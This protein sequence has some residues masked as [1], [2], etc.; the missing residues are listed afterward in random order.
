MSVHRKGVNRAAIAS[1]VFGR[2]VYAVN[3]YSLAAVFFLIKSELNQNVSGLGLVIS[4]F[5]VG[6]G[7]SQVPGGILAAK[8]GPRLTA[9]FGTAIASLAVLLTGLAGN[10]VE[11]AILRFFVG[12]GMAF[13]FAPGVTLM[14]RLLR[15]GSEGLGVGIYN[16]A[17]S[18][19]GV[20][21]LSGWS[22]LATVVGWRISLI[23]GGLLGLFTSVLLWVLV[24]EDSRR[25]Q[26]KVELGHLWAVLSDKWLIVVSIAMLGLEVGST[27]YSNFMPY[28][29]ETVAN[30]G[31]GEGGTIVSLAL[32][33]SLASAPF[34]GRLFDRFGNARRLLL[35]SGVLMA[36]G[37]AVAFFGTVYSAV[38]SGILV[39]LA[40]GSG[41]T[42]GFSA[43]RE[44]NKL[45]KEYE[46][47]AISWVN[48]I[49]L[50]GD[51]VPPLLYSYLVLQ[52]G[53]S[54]AWLY[55]AVLA[56]VLVVPVLFTKVSSQKQAQ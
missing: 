55:M 19:G 34:S 6:I 1:L 56:L 54:P 44:A 42:F 52:Y 18:L 39:G 36:L 28:Y 31:L 46:T 45:D 26:F 5:F 24:P 48:S 10:L 30:I 51:F 49:S 15:E 2:V 27:I 21:G 20:I 47:L 29:L 25:S 11:I 37:V 12:F 17:F 41:F 7:L 8:I 50:F 33:F 43:A 40:S 14:T 16:S 35:A 9:I 53:Y 38:L 22:V 13:V 4:T 32:L 23:I 3:W